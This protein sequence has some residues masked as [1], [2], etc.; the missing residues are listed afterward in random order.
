MSSVKPAKFKTP[1][2]ALC[3]RRKLRCDGGD[4][5]GPCSRTRTPVICTYVPKTVGQL[6]S[7]LPKGGACITCRQRKRRCDGTLPCI[8]CVKTSR[9]DE[10][11]YREKSRS[12]QKPPKPAT[13]DETSS[14]SG[15]SSSSRPSTPISS[16]SHGM[17]RFQHE[18]LD[19]PPPSDSLISWSEL[20]SMC[21]TID[22]TSAEKDLP[23]GLFVLP[24]LDS[25]S[26]PPPP[27]QVDPSPQDRTER[28]AMRNI[29]LE[30]SWQYGLSVTIAKRE[31]LSIGDVSGLIVD[32]I[33]VGICELMGHLHSQP[34]GWLTSNTQT[35]TEA[36]L[37]RFIRNKLES[38]SALGTDPLLCLQAFT[39]LSL[40]FAQKED[41]HSCQESL[42]KANN[43]AVH[44]AATLGLEDDPTDVWCPQ[45]DASYLSPHTVSGEVRAAF[46]FLV[47][48]DIQRGLILDL[49]SILDPGLMEKFRRLLGV[50]WADTEINFMRAKSILFLSDSKQLVAAWNRWEFGNPTPTAWSKCY[51]SLIEDIHSHISFLGAALM[52]VSYIPAL[53]GAQLTL[54]TCI[55]TC[56]AALAELH[57]LFAPSQPDSRQKHRE[58]VA[59]ITS[60]TRTFLDKDYQHLE[61]ILRICWSIAWRTLPEDCNSET[62]DNDFRSGLFF[63]H[64]ECNR[65]LRRTSSSVAP[66]WTAT[67]V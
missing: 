49:P 28:F 21:H 44:H 34:Q 10:C 31:A 57:G 65:R 23:D 37:D 2:C 12:K 38:A 19:V 50:H 66:S 25:I 29:F 26:F 32:P 48:T 59:E 14:D 51:W 11:Q 22:P 58:V 7:E 39:L 30:H 33:L 15:S 46:S 24:S 47:Y 36:E 43:I 64:A 8:T 18:Y 54:K 13:R 40:Y 61:P 3:R 35:A 6:R 4:P 55:I 1:T 9:P 20:D 41:T 5:C 27:F 17:L 63:L 16:S 45:F 42:V 60:I 67:G 53:Q 52:D 56:L 62:Q